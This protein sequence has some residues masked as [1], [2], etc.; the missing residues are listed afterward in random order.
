MVG[1]G[2]GERIL[3]G[4]RRRRG[5]R[6]LGRGWVLE[7]LV[8]EGGEVEVGEVEGGVDLGDFGWVGGVWELFGH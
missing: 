1:G 7:G 2:G 3:R 6:G 5:E 4:E 8:E